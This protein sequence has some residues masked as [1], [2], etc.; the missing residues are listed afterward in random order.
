MSAS[1]AG[2][3]KLVVISGPSGT[4][5]STVCRM[6]AEVDANIRISVSATTRPPRKNE[7]NGRDYHF[8]ER[9]EFERKVRNGEFVEHAE[10]AGHLYGTLKSEVDRAIAEGKILVMDI[11]VQG[12]EQVKKAYPDAI[13]IFLEPPSFDELLRRLNLRNT[14]SPEAKRQRIEIAKRE[15]AR[16]Q[17]Y[18]HQVVND[19]LNE[20]VKQIHG[21]IVGT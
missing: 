10:Y 21:I 3:G 14:D 7:K 5:K 8:I 19:D 9:D 2:T 11:D 13:T 4:G 20:A 15:M 6:L 12:G 1:T 17:E 18:R 16:R